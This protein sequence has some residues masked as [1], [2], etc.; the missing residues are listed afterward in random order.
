MNLKVMIGRKYSKILI[1]VIF[2]W[3]VGQ[4][5]LILICAYQVSND[6]HIILL[7]KNVTFKREKHV[8]HYCLK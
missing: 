7:F 5:F 4:Q 2:G 8:D 1:V 3:E 6:K